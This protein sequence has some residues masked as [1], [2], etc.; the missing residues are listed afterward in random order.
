MRCCVLGLGYIGLP[1]AALFAARG[2]DVLG[3]DVD[4]QRLDVGVHADHREPGLKDLVNAGLQ[5]GRLTVGP[6][7]EDADVFLICVASP[8]MPERPEATMAEIVS[9]VDS[10]VPVLQKGNLVIIEST[11]PPGTTEDIVM[12]RL[13]Q[14][15]GLRCGRDFHLAY[16]P[17]RVLPG[18]LIH[19]LM[20]NDRVVGGVNEE[21]ARRA[22]VL[23]RSVVAGEVLLTSTR[24]AEMAKLME[25]T[26]ASVNIALA[27]EFAVL[28]EQA[29]VDVNEAISLANRHP[30]VH[31]MKPGPGVGG[32]CI[33]V[34][35][36]FLVDWAP[37]KTGLI[38]RALKTNDSMPDHVAGAIC[39][40]LLRA[41]K[42]LGDSRVVLMGVAYKGGV[43]DVR[44]SPALSVASQLRK[45]GVDVVFQDPV[46]TTFPY[47]VEKDLLVSARGADA[48]V[49]ITDHPQ[50]LAIG[51]LLPKLRFVM[52]PPPVIADTRAVVAS[53]EGF[54]LWSLGHG[55][56]AP[57]ETESVRPFD[58]M[59]DTC[60]AEAS[61]SS[62]RNRKTVPLGH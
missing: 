48:L 8:R 13:E 27:N 9:A 55:F 16:C 59:E 12:P 15:S 14:A 58:P 56:E 3:V 6:R 25:N 61:P 24:T 51:S 60:P 18:N 5:S 22:A 29:D 43:D 50:Y 19:E 47:P 34:D 26:W 53:A 23:F 42:S 39:E 38:R 46:V 4:P 17:E 31:L 1:T 33:P 11:V 28:A 32:H 57:G 49:V 45:E 44:G 35:P 54:I 62:S 37:G 2:H 41:G 21:S 7:A 40:A 52:R 36:W 30:R 20:Q 10:I